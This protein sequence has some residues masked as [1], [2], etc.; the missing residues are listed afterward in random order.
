MPAVKFTGSAL[1]NRV[2]TSTY[3]GLFRYRITAITTEMGGVIGV[4]YT[5]PT[6]CSTSATPSSNTASCFPEYWTPSGYISPMRDWFNKYAVQEVLET[7]TTGGSAT[8]E[9]DY[10]YS[11][12]AW[13]YDDDENT[14]P[15]YRTYGQ[16]R[17]YQQVTTTTGNGAGDDRTKQVDSYYQGMDGDWLSSTSTR[18]VSLTDSQGGS[19]TDTAQLSGKIL[20]SASYLGSG[21]GVDHSTISSYWVSA[22]TAT[23]TR[24]GL[25]DLTA[26]ALSLI[27]I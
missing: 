27:H 8:K 10:L 11:G 1:E 14:K 19:H 16:W 2:D 18:S 26:R 12:A 3:P 7:D 25:P 20:E 17:G 15:K 4:S 13:H 23:R 21:G 6:A 5:L 24:S 22:A 9:T